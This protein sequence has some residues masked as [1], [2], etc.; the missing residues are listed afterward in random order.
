L[1]TPPALQKE[2]TMIKMDACDKCPHD[3]DLVLCNVFSMK[4]YTHSICLDCLQ[5]LAEEKATITAGELR[6]HILAEG[7]RAS[8]WTSGED[9]YTHSSLPVV[10]T[11]LGAGKFSV[12]MLSDLHELPNLVFT[13][14]RYH[15]ER[16]G[17]YE[18]PDGGW[19]RYTDL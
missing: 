5:S 7:L 16:N 17:M 19:V 10:L 3:Q 6:D 1:R 15:L 18:S 9:G 13:P 11:M 8:G 12:E 2:N 4:G 14:P